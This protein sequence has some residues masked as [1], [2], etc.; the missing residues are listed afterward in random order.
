MK[1]RFGFFL[2]KNICLPQPC[3]T[4]SSQSLEHFLL[5]FP[6]NTQPTTTAAGF[7]DSIDFVTESLGKNFNFQF[8]AKY[9]LARYYIVCDSSLSRH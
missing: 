3:K 2:K 4:K 6:Y 9:T 7:L 1:F 8:S 5:N